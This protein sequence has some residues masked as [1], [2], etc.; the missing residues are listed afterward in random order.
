MQHKPAAGNRIPLA[1]NI[2]RLGFLAC[3]LAAH[4]ILVGTLHETA[5]AEYGMAGA[6]AAASRAVTVRLLG[7]D[8]QQDRKPPGLAQPQHAHAAAIAAP[9]GATPRRVPLAAPA[10][11]APAVPVAAGAT[12]ET[13]AGEPAWLPAGRLTRL[14]SPAHHIDLDIAGIT[15]L[16]YE[17]RLELTLFID[18]GGKVI[19]VATV[20]DLQDTAEAG[21]FAQRVA[22]RFREARFVPGE[23]DGRPV[24]AQMTITVVSES[25][26]PRRKDAAPSAPAASVEIREAGGITR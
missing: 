1:G 2:H 4:A 7:D 10:A 16:P 24:P 18:A 11:T 12:T 8:E 5:P 25:I 9:A 15:L 21:A 23:V 20:S 14:P 3:S 19:E 26:P 13:A 22:Q 17:G 6:A